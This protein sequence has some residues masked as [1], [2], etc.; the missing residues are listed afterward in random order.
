[1][2]MSPRA[3]FRLRIGRYFVSCTGQ[4]ILRRDSTW[5][6]PRTGFRPGT[7]YGAAVAPELYESTSSFAEPREELRPK[8]VRE[9]AV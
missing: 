9:F 6:T 5:E 1:M 7:K 2:W 4:P 8:A 3:E